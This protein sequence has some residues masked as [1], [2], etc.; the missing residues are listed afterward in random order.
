MKWNHYNLI[1]FTESHIKNRDLIIKMLKYE[2][3]IIHSDFGKNIYEDSTHELFSSLETMYVMHRITLNAF[4]FKTTD[5]DIINY[6]KIFSYYYKSPYEYD[7]EVLDCVT[8]MREN[9]CVYYTNKDFKINDKFEDVNV[10]DIDG[11]TKISLF[12]KINKNDNYTI[13]GAFS[14]S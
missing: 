11:K 7:K 13:V 9:K 14:N 12:D 3:T 6:R 5:N 8:Y 2:D 1:H 10:Y 4:S